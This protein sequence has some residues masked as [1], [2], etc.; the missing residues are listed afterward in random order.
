MELAATTPEVSVV[1]VR[2]GFRRFA[3]PLPHGSCVRFLYAKQHK[4]RG[5]AAEHGSGAALFVTGVA[6]L[7]DASAELE[8]R[9]VFGTFGGIRAVELDVVGDCGMGPVTKTRTAKVWFHDAASVAN[10]MAAQTCQLATEA[11]VD[12]A[13]G[14]GRKRLQ[15]R[16]QAHLK[17]RPDPERLQ[18]QADEVVAAFEDAETAEEQRRAALREGGTDEDGFTLVTYKKKTRAREDD[19]GLAGL[20]KR[21]RKKKKNTELGN[22]YRHEI[23]E[24]KREQLAKLREQFEADKARVAKM[25]E[26][27]KFRPH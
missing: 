4:M 27:R 6:H 11:A 16:L 2:G 1:T 17:R 23:R 15:A 18:D 8:L 13:P 24:A 3:A 19:G 25:K 9:R 22:F 21:R 5:G 26:S 12:V 7:S 14:S 10:A 20:P